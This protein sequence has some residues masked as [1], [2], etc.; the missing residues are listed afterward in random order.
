MTATRRSHTRY[1]CNRLVEEEVSMSSPIVRCRPEAAHWI[2]GGLLMLIGVPCLVLSL[3]DRVLDPGHRWLEGILSCLL[4]IPA[5]V[6]SRSGSRGRKSWP[7]GAGSDGVVWGVGASFRG[8]RYRTSW[9]MRR[10]LVRMVVETSHETLSW[11]A[12]DRSAAIQSLRRAIEQNAAGAP[13][14]TWA[15]LGTRPEEPRTLTFEYRASDIWTMGIMLWTCVIVWV[16]MILCLTGP[17]AIRRLPETLGHMGWLL[18]L[19]GASPCWVHALA[20]GDGLPLP[21]CPPRSPTSAAPAI[22]AD[23]R[24]LVFEE[25]S[26]RLEATWDE[27]MD[28]F[29]APFSG[30]TAASRYVVITRSGAFDFTPHLYDV[31]ILRQMIAHYAKS[32]PCPVAAGA[33][34]TLGGDA[35]RWTRSPQ[36]DRERVYHYRTRTNRALL[37]LPSRWSSCAPFC[38]HLLRQALSTSAAWG[39]RLVCRH[40][41]RPNAVWL[42]ALL[43]RFRARQ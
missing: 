34:E 14:S 29:I 22:R 6:Y 11:P 26:R 5:L 8:Q 17:A 9:P 41:W 42:V 32:A 12:P 15:I 4:L 36:G 18:G 19:L 2:L 21:P 1:Y 13:V 10:G 7:M 3:S 31:A 40:P 20:A 43:Y 30:I 37:W 24:G 28:Y 33:D 38:L 25:G 27:V 35:L 23:A 39:R 16:G